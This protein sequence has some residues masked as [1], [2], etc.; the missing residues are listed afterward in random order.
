M[1]VREEPREHIPD[2][3]VDEGAEAGQEFLVLRGDREVHG[4]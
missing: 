4:G 1:Y 2:L 3:A